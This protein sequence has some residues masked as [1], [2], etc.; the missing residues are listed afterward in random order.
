MNAHSI[1]VLSESDEYVE[2]RSRP[3]APNLM[4]RVTASLPGRAV[5]SS[6][7]NFVVQP[8]SASSSSGSE[9]NDNDNGSEDVNGK[10]KGRKR[11]K[12]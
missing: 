7:D 3:I 12:L 4:E 10:G 9:T 1:R 6:F 8:S 11:T 5:S 2:P